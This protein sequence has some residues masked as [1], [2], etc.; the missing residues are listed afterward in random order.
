MTKLTYR[1]QNYFGLSSF[2]EL[3]KPELIEIS[4]KE[5]RKLPL[6]KSSLSEHALQKRKPIERRLRLK[7]QWLPRLQRPKDL[8]RK[9]RERLPFSK[10]IRKREEIS[11]D[12]CQN[13]LSTMKR[14]T[15]K[16][17]R[18]K[19]QHSVLNSKTTTSQTT[20]LRLLLTTI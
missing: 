15:L 6:Q 7:P 1:R 4:S 10:L 14:R 13:R 5:I 19:P 11:T 17:L 18:P 16:S 8:S 9:L 20:L 3:L 12:C 2:K